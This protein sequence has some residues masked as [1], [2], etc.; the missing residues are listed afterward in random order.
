MLGDILALSIPPNHYMYMYVNQNI[1]NALGCC[2][3]NLQA[4]GTRVSEGGVL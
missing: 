2:A 4:V 3:V 1:W